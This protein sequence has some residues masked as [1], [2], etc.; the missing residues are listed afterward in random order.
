MQIWK[1]GI[2]RLDD[3]SS[4]HGAYI[5]S[6]QIQDA[7]GPYFAPTYPWV[8]AVINIIPMLKMEEKDVQRCFVFMT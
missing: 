2:A 4:I 5:V 3:S 8:W 1:A 7:H 6:K